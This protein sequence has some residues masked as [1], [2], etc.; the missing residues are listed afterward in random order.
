[1]KSFYTMK[2]AINRQNEKT[3][4][5]QKRT[6]AKHT[7]GK[8]Y[9]EHQKLQQKQNKNKMKIKET[10]NHPNHPVFHMGKRPEQTFLQRRHSHVQQIYSM[11]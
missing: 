1:M 2:K 11:K 10:K 6:W 3:I 9:K 5:G 4:C 7:S 8:E